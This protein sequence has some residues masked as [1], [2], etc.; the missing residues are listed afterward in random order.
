MEKIL[1]YSAVLFVITFAGGSFP[2]W[3]RSWKDAWMKYLLG[4]SGA[5]LLGI[6]LLH[7][8]PENIEHYGRKAGVLIL[9]G[10]FLQQVIQKYTHGVEHGHIHTHHDGAPIAVMPVFIGLSV[11]A[12]SEGLPLGILYKDPA[13]LSSLYMAV[14][15]HKLPEAMLV[16]SLALYAT[17]SKSRALL[18]VLLFAAITPLA[19]L[20]SCYAGEHS[21]AIA[22]IIEFCIPVVAGSFIHIAT[23]IFFESGTRAHEMNW[24]KWLAI[25]LGLGMALLTLMGEVAH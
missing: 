16:G 5:F 21:Q 6:T 23:T 4:F 2:L 14:A 8:V 19:S 10:F 25:L 7:L 20:L 11:H 9:A 13:T 3:K 12:F 18:L 15:L 22:A 17:H 1:L 24:K